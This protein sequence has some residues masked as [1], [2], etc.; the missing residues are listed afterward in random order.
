[1]RSILKTFILLIIVP[2]VFLALA[3]GYVWLRQ[4]NPHQGLFTCSTNRPILWPWELADVSL[5]FNGDQLGGQA[6]ADFSTDVVLVIDRSGSMSGTPLSEAKAAATNFTSILVHPSFRVGVV[7]FDH[8]NYVVHPISTDAESLAR[9]ISTLDSRGA[10]NIG[11]ALDLA[12]RE[13]EHAAPADPPVMRKAIIL[14]SDG[15][16]NSKTD[17]AAIAKKIHAQG[18]DVFAIGLG[19]A[20]DS[21]LL[22]QVASQPKFFTLTLDP[23][24]LAGIYLD[25]GGSLA[26]SIGF[27]GQVVENVN[28][29]LFALPKAPPML[30]TQF[31]PHGGLLQWSLPMLFPRRMT[32]T[33]TVEPKIF[34]ILEPAREPATMT[35]ATPQGLK[36][37]VSGR[38]PK[39][40]VITWPLLFWLY[41]PA[42]LYAL[43]RLYLLANTGRMEP[44]IDVGTSP[45]PIYRD[46]PVLAD[47]PWIPALSVEPVSTLFIGLGWTGRWALT[48]L[49]YRLHEMFGDEVPGEY[50]FLCL[51]T[52][53][54]EYRG[55][56]AETVKLDTVELSDD[57]VL[58]L[59][60]D[61]GEPIARI[62]RASQ[63][64]PHLVWFDP[65]PFKDLPVDVKK[66]SGGTHGHR[67]LARLALLLDLEKGPH[68][69]TI[70][71][72]LHSQLDRLFQSSAPLGMHQVF[73]FG[74]ATGGVGSGWFIDL[75]H[76]LRRLSHRHFPDKAL[77]CYGILIRSEESKRGK[78]TPPALFTELDRVAFAGEL[79]HLKEFDEPAADDETLLDRVRRGQITAPLFDGLLLFQEDASLSAGCRPSCGVFAEIADVVSLFVEK[80]T[81]LDWQYHRQILQMQE[82]QERRRLTEGTVSAAGAC[83]LRF[84]VR[85]LRDRLKC[86]FLMHLFSGIMLLDRDS[87]SKVATF[88]ASP[89]E[90]LLAILKEWQRLDYLEQDC[91]EFFHKFRHFCQEGVIPP[92]SDYA[93]QIDLS[94]DEQQWLRQE[95]QR[96]GNFLH[97]ALTH[98]L[99]A[100]DVDPSERVTK[101]CGRIG[102]IYHLC[103]LL[104]EKS[105]VFQHQ[106]QQQLA[107]ELDQPRRERLAALTKLYRQVNLEMLEELEKWTFLL[108]GPEVLPD[109]KVAPKP[110][111]PGFY[112]RVAR[113]YQE[114]AEFEK[115]VLN[116][117]KCRWYLSDAEGAVTLGEK[118]IF[119]EVLTERITD[120]KGML[121]RLWFEAGAP[122][123]SGRFAPSLELVFIGEKKTVFQA[124]PDLPEMLLQEL[125]GICD[126]L[127]GYLRTTPVVR[128]TGATIPPKSA[129]DSL[130]Y[131]RP[132]VRW[133]QKYLDSL[134]AATPLQVQILGRPP[135]AVLSDKERQYQDDLQQCLQQQSSGQW[136][137]LP[138]N[139]GDIHA[140]QV[141]VWVNNIPLGAVLNLDQAALWDPQRELIYGPEKRLRDYVPKFHQ[142]WPDTR[143]HPSLGWLL[144]TSE[145]FGTGP[146]VQDFSTFTRL[147]ASGDIRLK[148]KGIY[149]QYVI[150]LRDKEYILSGDDGEP[151]LYEA[152]LQ[153]LYGDRIDEKA[154]ADLAQQAAGITPEQLLTT[155]K[156]IESEVAGL[157][158]RHPVVGRDEQI[159]LLILTELLL[160]QQRR[161]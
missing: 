59:P 120:E 74:S 108:I 65:E 143:F 131:A 160:I 43:W 105:E 45:P 77:S 146:R 84:P 123:T 98:Y 129:A 67:A 61:L 99:R 53:E 20:V 81:L 29:R 15:C 117:M 137:Q 135:A 100:M 148:E 76:L 44:P 16:D 106:F 104:M 149:R 6:K 90:E 8:E 50:G 22:R 55:D 115:T 96:Y 41:L 24:N 138:I 88:R 111:E 125:G 49:K 109:P 1:M 33:Y 87:S 147:W 94:L 28:T 82:V 30:L 126:R 26:D 79:A 80:N 141:C 47:L 37:L 161:G 103:R 75:A 140:Y 70:Y 72:K 57:E 85:E 110:T 11:G 112:N 40:L 132:A 93:I 68:Q 54:Q 42:L 152:A 127:T 63:N 60:A 46:P 139:L 5:N 62:A 113:R 52:A 36:T 151:G 17:V 91:P 14:L 155:I 158:S 64:P 83:S 38:H 27:Q 86:R 34:G 10:T 92:L 142:K 102:Q 19:F 124:V 58:C 95:G 133:S 18:V 121:A 21:N 7:A 25:F 13:L 114:L 51:D 119:D 73:I 145:D 69:S 2:M 116:E 107:A 66:V 97:N 154:K 136:R 39:I 153:F 23:K 32:L 122:S 31:D 130:K 159:K 156:V 101:R 48:H 128:K 118:E 9:A 150:N 89:P 4:P 144:L 71:L 157:L 12:A 78:E 56:N 134:G 3:G 35:Y